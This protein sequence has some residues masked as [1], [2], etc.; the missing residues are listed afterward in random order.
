MFQLMYGSTIF[1]T[2]ARITSNREFDYHRT[3]IADVCVKLGDCKPSNLKVDGSFAR[4]DSAKAKACEG[5][6][7]D[8]DDNV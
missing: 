7:G 2:L 4:A 1:I 3:I 8:N 6:K 5:G